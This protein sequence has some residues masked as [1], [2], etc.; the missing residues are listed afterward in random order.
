MTI[1]QRLKQETLPLHQQLEQ[2]VDV[3]HRLQSVAAYR[4]LLRA[5]YGFYAPLEQALEPFD[6]R[7]M[8]LDW[9][10]RRKVER[11]ETDLQRFG[12]DHSTIPRCTQL[13]AMTDA[14]SALGCLYVL[15]GATL[16]GQFIQKELAARLH[17]TAENGAA[18][19]NSY[20][21]SV[22]PMWAA[23]RQ[24][25]VN[26]STNIEREDQI[27]RAAKDTFEKF[28]AWLATALRL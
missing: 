24:V 7:V 2:R 11:L 12:V 14:A 15:E 25:L 4:E 1:L 3:L 6:W 17:I 27:V 23:F 5:F 21:E 20:G 22:G 26:F 28:D 9:S 18:F 16:G 10:E 13:P 19:F 8:G